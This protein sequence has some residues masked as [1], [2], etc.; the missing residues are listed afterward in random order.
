MNVELHIEELV[1][2]GFERGD[3][4]HISEAV[5][6]ELT[7]LFAQGVPPSLAQGGEIGRLDGGGF[8]MTAGMQSG[9]I[10][11]QIAR[12]IYGGLD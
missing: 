11:A 9:A 1:L 5:Q 3:R 2:H 10:G 8:E 12:S 4:H 7:R 6:Q